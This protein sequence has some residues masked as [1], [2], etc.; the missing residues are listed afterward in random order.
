MS[1]PAEIRAAQLTLHV[2]Q[3]IEALRS[4]LTRLETARDWAGGWPDPCWRASACW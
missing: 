4:P 3:L 2:E 1:A